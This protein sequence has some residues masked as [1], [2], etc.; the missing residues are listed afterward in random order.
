MRQ[1]IHHLC[2]GK[3]NFVKY[4][5]HGEAAFTAIQVADAYK[6]GDSPEKILNDLYV[7]VLFLHFID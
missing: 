1:S 4:V 7:V 6:K 5:P 2:S 3:E